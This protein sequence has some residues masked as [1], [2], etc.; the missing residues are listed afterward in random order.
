MEAA[1]RHHG[2]RIDTRVDVRSDLSYRASE[3]HA[4]RAWFQR[5]RKTTETS[6]PGTMADSAHPPGLISVFRWARRPPR[7]FLKRSWRPGTVGSVHSD[8]ERPVLVS[9]R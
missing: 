6:Q 9:E 8:Q 1:R 7:D 3:G 2:L 4:A 5:R